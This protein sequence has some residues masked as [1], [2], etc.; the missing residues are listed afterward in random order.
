V[1][2]RQYK[3]EGGG[4]T[5]RKRARVSTAVRALRVFVRAG[6]LIACIFLF[7]TE[8]VGVE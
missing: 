7:K 8:L 1:R 4:A 3:E 6:V 5:A 2:A